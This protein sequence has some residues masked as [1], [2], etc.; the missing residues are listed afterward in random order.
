MLEIR[1]FLTSQI[2]I[3]RFTLPESGSESY[4]AY[5]CHN[6]EICIFFLKKIANWP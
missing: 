5:L 6:I 4:R 1:N 3:H 2:Q